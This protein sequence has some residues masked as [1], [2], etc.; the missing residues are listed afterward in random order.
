MLSFSLC[1]DAV[2]GVIY[3]GDSLSPDTQSAGIFILD[4]SA[5]RDIK[6]LNLCCLSAT[7]FMAIC[8]NSPNRLKE[9][10]HIL[11]SKFGDCVHTHFNF[12]LNRHVHQRYGIF[13][14]SSQSVQTV[15]VQKQQNR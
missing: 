2:Q 10:A 12:Y 11:A 8:D 14:R 6:N 3:E 15:P 5:P 9:S 13:I 7:P 1:K 4:F